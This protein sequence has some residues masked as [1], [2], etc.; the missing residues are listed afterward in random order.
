[1][2]LGALPSWVA[3]L[4]KLAAVVVA[5]VLVVACK[6][7][8][9]ESAEE[10]EQAAAAKP[11]VRIWWAQWAPAD[12][13]QTL[14]KEYTAQSG[15]EVSVHQIPWPKFQ[16]QVFQEFGKKQTAFDIVVGDSQWLGRGATKSLYLDL[17]DWLPGAVDLASMHPLAL[18]YLA[19]YPTGSG[20]Y[21]AAPC[22]T[23]A[24]GFA[25]RK[26]WFESPEESAAFESK[27]SRKLAPPKTWEEL[28]QIAEFFQRPDEK[29]YG[30]ALLTGRGYDELVMG[31]EQVLYAF[32][33]SWGDFE[34][35]SV[36]GHLDGDG[37][38]QSLD[39]FKS[40]LSLSPPGGTKLSFGEVLEPLQNGTA[41][42]AMN[43]FAF[44][45][46][47]AEAMGDKVGFF[48]MPSHEGRRFASLGG[49]GLSI[50]KKTAP[51]QQA[52]AKKFIAWFLQEAQQKKWTQLPGGF[53]AHA[54]ILKSDEFKAAAPYNAAFS[55]SMDILQDF[56][57]VPTYNELLSSVVRHVGESLDG[58]KS[59]EQ[60]LTS[61]RE[62]HETI[63][64][65]MANQNPP[66]GQ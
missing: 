7:S 66:D 50:S 18:K 42:M 62:E 30:V 41:A 26:D 46:S 65:S 48:A 58:T 28:K 54:G 35:R 12:S 55:E 27:H 10:G 25:Y 47:L 14:A 13:L 8:G 36:A 9:G 32:G 53:T 22:E 38:V 11:T 56:W 17:S 43:Y 5:A 21:W 51:E 49:Q 29:K 1:M 23:D 15:V 52:E 61:L 63:L 19:E 6:S 40:L 3:G 4:R 2:P 64:K 34:T 60:A 31:F 59:S 37:A 16:D 33:G 24:V 45:P 39:F 20:K 57:N 44:F